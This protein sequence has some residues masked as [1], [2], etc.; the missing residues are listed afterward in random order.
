[1]SRDAGPEGRAGAVDPQVLMRHVLQ[2]VEFQY[3]FVSHAQFL[4]V[5]HYRE[6]LI[7][8][9]A[10]FYPDLPPS[11]LAREL[12]EEFARRVMEMQP[13]EVED[14]ID[15]LG[16]LAERCYAS[17]GPQTAMPLSPQA[18]PADERHR[19]MMKR[20]MTPC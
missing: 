16:W 11:G 12:H 14:A 13:G 17:R 15:E 5:E 10:S 3:Q 7:V 18:G 20:L 2:V 4:T 1:M 19:I 6:M 9:A 8:L